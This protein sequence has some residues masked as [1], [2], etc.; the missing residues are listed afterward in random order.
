MHSGSLPRVV[1]VEQP[2][3]VALPGLDGAV[4]KGA[5]DR[6]DRNPDGSHTIVEY[7]SRLPVSSMFGAKLSKSSPH[8]LQ[9]QLYMLAHQQSA[10]QDEAAGGVSGR[11]DGVVEAIGGGKQLHSSPVSSEQVIDVMATALSQIRKQKFG[12]TPSLFSCQFCNYSNLC[13]ESLA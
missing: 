12:A 8:W 2:F 9:L 4:L 5:W 3:E 11:V 1:A 6:I 13:N 7:K 10:K